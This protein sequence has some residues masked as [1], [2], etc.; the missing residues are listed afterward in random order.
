[1]K[2]FAF[3]LTV[4]VAAGCGSSA[5]SERIAQLE[6]R[7]AQ[8]EHQLSTQTPDAEPSSAELLEADLIMAKHIHVVGDDGL[9]RVEITG[10]PTMKASGSTQI[11]AD[12]VTIS[13]TDGQ[14]DVTTWAGGI[15]R[16]SL[17]ANRFTE[18]GNSAQEDDNRTR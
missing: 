5:D 15:A 4:V 16:R 7:I 3:A 17:F 18:P 13:A 11:A 2:A 6:R 12:S 9:T 8:L 1:M 14:A 10:G